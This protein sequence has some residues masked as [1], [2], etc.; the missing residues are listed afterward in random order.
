MEWP[1]G[2][3]LV[4]GGGEGLPNAVCCCLGCDE[5]AIRPGVFELVSCFNEFHNFLVPL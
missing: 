1:K 4:R 2:V 3:G 5:A